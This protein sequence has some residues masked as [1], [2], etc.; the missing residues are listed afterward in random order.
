MNATDRAKIDSSLLPHVLVDDAAA[1]KVLRWPAVRALEDPKHYRALLGLPQTKE[2]TRRYL[3]AIPPQKCKEIMKNL[4]IQLL[5]AREKYLGGDHLPK[6]DL[7]WVEQ[8]LSYL[9][10]DGRLKKELAGFQLGQQQKQSV[11][12]MLN[13]AKQLRMD[14]T[15]ESVSAKIDSGKANECKETVFID[16]DIRLEDKERE[17]RRAADFASHFESVIKKK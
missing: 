9:T 12:E 6:D 10:G 5:E 13:K 17:S 1:T 7:R 2:Q 3:T 4:S 14:L 8:L 11:R 15:K 16:R